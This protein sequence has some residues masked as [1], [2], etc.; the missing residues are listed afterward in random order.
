ML[1]KYKTE[2]DLREYL[3]EQSEAFKQ[4]KQKQRT[5]AEKLIT[6]EEDKARQTA[7]EQIAAET[8]AQQESDVNNI[9]QKL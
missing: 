7:Q 5:D 3:G 9:A 4:F 8:A 1:G 6:A 2:A